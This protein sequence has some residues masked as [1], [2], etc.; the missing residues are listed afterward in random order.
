MRRLFLCVCLVW[1]GACALSSEEG[2]L[3]GE[4]ASTFD[5]LETPSQGSPEC[6]SDS[7]RL[8]RSCEDEDPVCVTKP[9]DGTPPEIPCFTTYLGQPDCRAS[10]TPDAYCQRLLGTP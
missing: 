8:P 9:L 2:A 7:V 3:G 6:G 4:D 1:C 10:R 5:A